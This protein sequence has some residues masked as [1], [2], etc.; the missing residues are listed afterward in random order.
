[1]EPT[2]VGR[3]DAEPRLCR[4]PARLGC[5]ENPGKRD[6]DHLIAAL[7]AGRNGHPATNDTRTLRRQDLRFAA[8]TSI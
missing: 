2:K 7:V 1:M 4:R 8:A 6:Q 3:L 5:V